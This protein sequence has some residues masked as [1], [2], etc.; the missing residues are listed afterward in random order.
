MPSRSSPTPSSPPK[1]SQPPTDEI[2]ARAVAAPGTKDES[3][4]G[5]TGAGRSAASFLA[6]S[7]AFAAACCARAESGPSVRGGPS[8]TLTGTKSVPRTSSVAV[9]RSELSRPI[10]ETAHCCARP[11]A[12]LT[13][14][15]LHGWG[16]RAAA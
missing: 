7:R 11:A 1:P 6:A 16:S 13:W 8:A 12:L 5:A 15:S 3:P 9:P 10:V 2:A 14:S 4:T